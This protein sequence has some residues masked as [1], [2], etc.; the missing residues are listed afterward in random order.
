MLEFS[1]PRVGDSAPPQPLELASF[2]A[3]RDWHPLTAQGAV[4]QQN[5]IFFPWLQPVAESHITLCGPYTGFHQQP[6]G[7]FSVTR[8]WNWSQNVTEASQ[9]HETC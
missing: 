1:P 8:L 3:T 4:A 9:T 2:P 6:S 7:C 5:D